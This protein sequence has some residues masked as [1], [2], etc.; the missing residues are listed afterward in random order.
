MPKSPSPENSIPRYPTIIANLN[1][2]GTATISIDKRSQQIAAADV[3]AT[4]QLVLEHAAWVAETLGRPVRLNCTDPDGAWQLAVHPDG[5]VDELGAAPTVARATPGDPGAAATVTRATPVDE[6]GTA[7]TVAR[8]T[9][10]NGEHEPDV[11]DEQ[12]PI[13]GHG[14]LGPRISHDGRRLLIRLFA[15]FALLA[16]AGSATVLA[17]SGG[18]P[19]RV[20]PDPPAPKTSSSPAIKERADAAV[21]AEAQRKSERHA[22]V[23]RRRAHATARER[24]AERRRAS[25]K[26]AER[27]A[28]ER[29]RSATARRVAAARRRRV[30]P[31]RPAAPRLAPPVVN[32]RPAPAPP[33]SF[34]CGDFDIC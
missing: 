8:A 10:R 27:Q 25:A 12:A 29:N 33:P 11:P 19:A 15:L 14:P 6:F 18:G 22:T 30:A 24:A 5:H 13:G 3:D 4:R 7:P 9:P 32:R 31:P 16:V 17:L 26:R 28:R 1:E 2:D 23:Q 21:I 20:A 34:A